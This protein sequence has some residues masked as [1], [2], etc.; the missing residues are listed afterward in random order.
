M[1]SL[2]GERAELHDGRAVRGEQ[3]QGEGLL[4]L[5]LPRQGGDYELGR[6]RGRR[7]RHLA[8]QVGGARPVPVGEVRRHRPTLGHHPHD[9][10]PHRRREGVEPLDQP[11]LGRDHQPRAT[12]RGHHA[13][14]P[15]DLDVDGD[16]VR[17]GVGDDDPSHATRSLAA[18]DEMHHV[19]R[20]RAGRQ[21]PPA[22]TGVGNHRQL[23]G[24]HAGGLLAPGTDDAPRLVLE[25][26]GQLAVHVRDV[27]AV[28]ADQGELQPWRAG[29]GGSLED[30][31]GR[32]DDAHPRLGGPVVPTVLE[33]TVLDGTGAGQDRLGEV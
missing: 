29:R 23:A 10:V 20:H 27:E 32:A 30:L 9:R 31:P 16:R 7:G 33:R 3:A 28:G 4:P 25:A 24:H 1:P 12:H 17:G 14:L 6:G 22:R 18:P 5:L 2:P 11:A 15:E 21:G 19:G 26:H 13:V 8:A